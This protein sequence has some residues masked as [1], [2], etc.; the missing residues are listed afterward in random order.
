MTT[1]KIDQGSNMHKIKHVIRLCVA[2]LGLAMLQGC[3]SVSMQPATLVTTVPADK[4]LVTFVRPSVFAGDG[5]GVDI[6]DGDHYIGGL[7]A[8]TLVQYMTTP[9]HHLFLGNTENWSY[10]EANLEPGKQY[11]IKANLFPG[12]LYGRVALGVPK[13]DDKRFATWLKYDPK[14]PNAADLK[15]VEE[16]KHAE[17]ETVI[18][19]FDEGKYTGASHIGPQEGFKNGEL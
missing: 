1:N 14:T 12:I 15:A 2:I 19:N 13:N 10:T 9:G 3:A 8:G 7:N 6:W 5:V 18:K 4:A 16:K 17:V 11:F